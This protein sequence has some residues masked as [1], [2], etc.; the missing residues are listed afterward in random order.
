MTGH[1]PVA[2]GLVQ[3]APTPL[4]SR[5]PITHQL[6][7]E[8]VAAERL[9][10]SPFPSTEPGQAQTERRSEIDRLT[11]A[12]NQSNHTLE[13]AKKALEEARESVAIRM[14]ERDALLRELAAIQNQL[15][16]I[17][18]DPRAYRLD[19]TSSPDD[20]LSL[21][22]TSTQES[23]AL[24]EHR[25]GP[26]NLDSGLSEISIVFQA[27]V[28]KLVASKYTTSGVRRPREL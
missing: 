2:R 10:L 8:T 16:A 15:G 23:S 6:R 5:L 20:V 18:A 24:D 9:N 7:E 12:V 27:A 28:P 1:L 25:S 14:R 13:N 4:R 11:E 22:S 3:S 26:R 17:R 19:L 21:L